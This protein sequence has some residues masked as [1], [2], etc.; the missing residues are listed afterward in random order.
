MSLLDNFLIE[1]ER[2]YSSGK[3]YFYIRGHS[4]YETK[5]NP[6]TQLVFNFGIEN[7]F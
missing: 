7:T 1:L 6:L 4:V 2:I 5:Q 3:K